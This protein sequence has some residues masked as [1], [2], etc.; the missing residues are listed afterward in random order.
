MFV[1]NIYD[2]FHDRLEKKSNIL[3]YIGSDVLGG[4]KWQN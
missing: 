3:Y 1:V 2:K 4:E